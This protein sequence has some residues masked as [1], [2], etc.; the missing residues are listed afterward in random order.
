LIKLKIK[1]MI[2]LLYII[3]GALWVFATILLHQIDGVNLVVW[4]LIATPFI[5]LRLIRS[6]LLIKLIKRE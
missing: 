5:L 3:V 1:V 2:R 6:T 4:Y